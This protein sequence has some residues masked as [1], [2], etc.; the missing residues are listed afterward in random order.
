[1]RGA[2]VWLTGFVARPGVFF[3]DLRASAPV[4][5]S[6]AITTFM[7]WGTGIYLSESVLSSVS[8]LPA[9]V[10]VGA[11]LG[12]LV[13]VAFL[14]V[15]HIVARA[16]G[17]RGDMR[18]LAGLWGYTYLPEIVTG[19]LLALVLRFTAFRG[20][21]DSSV[22]GLGPQWLVGIA[23]V[24]LVVAIWSLVLRLQV[25]RV[26]Y[27]RGVLVCLL[28]LV[29][30][31]AAMDVVS[32][33][34]QLAVKTILVPVELTSVGVMDPMDPRV[35]RDIRVILEKEMSLVP[36]SGA[37]TETGTRMYVP[38]NTIAYPLK[39]GDAVVFCRDEHTRRDLRRHVDIGIPAN[40]GVGGNTSQLVAN[41]AVARV[42]GLGGEVV[43]VKAGRV[44]VNGQALGE[45]YVKVPGD[46]AV[47]P[48]RVPEGSFF[49]LGDNRSLDPGTYG[50][51][52]VEGEKI[53]GRMLRTW[54]DVMIPLSRVFVFG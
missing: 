52:I 54:A 36:A 17:G 53:L 47:P 44:L 2:W 35:A 25:L 46:F 34:P 4:W 42:V 24:A 8:W 45:P 16:L 27:A 9:H 31:D 26:A 19:L 10:L 6:L 32:W 20:R 29:L 50:G 18:G 37:E 3:H 11:I 30:S 41:V 7:C 14:A 49:L 1:M 23:I 40:C 51:G 12:F 38:V 5:P 48:T 15:I 39:K 28:V 33:I 13:A 22:G 21:V 43:E